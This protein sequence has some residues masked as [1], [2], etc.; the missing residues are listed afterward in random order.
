M[1]QHR[2]AHVTISTGNAY[3]YLSDHLGSTAVVASGDGKSVQW[4]AD[5]FPF[6]AQRQQRRPGTTAS[7][8]PDRRRRHLT[9]AARRRIGLAMKKRWAERKS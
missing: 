8:E 6:G 1:G 7:G 4:E 5:F 9:A 3:Y 2:I